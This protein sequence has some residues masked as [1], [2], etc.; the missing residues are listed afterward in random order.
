[1]SELQADQDQA[2]ARVAHEIQQFVVPR[3]VDRDLARPHALQRFQRVHQR[4]EAIPVPKQIVVDKEYQPVGRQCRNFGCNLVG[5]PLGAALTVEGVDRAELACEAATA[6]D[7]DEVHR[8]ILLAVEDAAIKVRAVM[9]VGREPIRISLL[10]RTFPRILDNSFPLSVGVAY[11]ETISI[12]GRLLGKQS[13]VRAAHH[14]RN[15]APAIILGYLVGAPRGEA[16]DRNGDE[17][18]RHRS[19]RLHSLVDEHRVDV[20]R[21][22]GLEQGEHQ[23][24][25]CIGRRTFSEL[26]TDERDVPH[27][28]I[29]RKSDFTPPVSH[30][31]S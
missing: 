27:R 4:Y 18:G 29:P 23:G 24:G 1:M 31:R 10:E 9:A 7:L 25:H 17:I 30:N 11:D 20:R 3:D 8:R 14:D 15:S 19:V 2:A 6:A 21:G 13:H 5:W 28:K 22:R 12:L 26:R 16:F